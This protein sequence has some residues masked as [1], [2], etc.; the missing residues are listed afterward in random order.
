MDTESWDCLR[1]QT[2]GQLAKVE[3][4]CWR[5]EARRAWRKHRRL[6]VTHR[7]PG[8]I[9]IFEIKTTKTPLLEPKPFRGDLHAPNKLLCATI[10]QVFDQRS[11]LTTNFH[12]KKVGL[13][14]MQDTHVEHVHC[15]VIAGR[16]PDTLRGAVSW[17]FSETRPRTLRSSPSTNCLRNFVLSTRSCPKVRRHLPVSRRSAK[18][19]LSQTSTRSSSFPCAVLCWRMWTLLQFRHPFD[20]LLHTLRLLL[21]PVPY[22]LMRSAALLR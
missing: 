4:T 8:R 16:S 7:L 19:P 18:A 13:R 20:M 9:A 17:I 5:N 12:A 3:I 21:I 15:V 14:G 10:S 11:E 2:L 22:A 1:P 6:P